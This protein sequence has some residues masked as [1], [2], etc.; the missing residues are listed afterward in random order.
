[1]A[2]RTRSCCP[3]CGAVSYESVPGK[4]NVIPNAIVVYGY[5]ADRR[6]FSCARCGTRVTQI[7]ME[8][9]ADAK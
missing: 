6:V 4:T 5:F 3:D 9:L 8:R 7:P 1:M 2:D